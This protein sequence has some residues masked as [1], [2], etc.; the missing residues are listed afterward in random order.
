MRTK[1]L[2]FA[3]ILFLIAG[4]I[5]VASALLERRTP[6]LAIGGAFIAI[7]S[8]VIAISRKSRNA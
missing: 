5:M 6:F 8:A 2:K 1:R 7:G 3:G 4:C